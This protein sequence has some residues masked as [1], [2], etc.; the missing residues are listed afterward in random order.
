MRRIMGDRVQESEDDNSTFQLRIGSTALR[1]NPRNND[2]CDDHDGGTSAE[3]RQFAAGC[4][5]KDFWSN[6]RAVYDAFRYS[7]IYPWPDKRGPRDQDP[8]PPPAHGE[9]QDQL[10]STAFY[11]DRKKL[12]GQSFRLRK[13][14]N[15]KMDWR[16][17]THP[18][19]GSL[20]F[21]HKSDINAMGPGATASIEDLEK[22]V[23]S[24][25]PDIP[26]PDG[27]TVGL[28]Y[29]EDMKAFEDHASPI[30]LGHFGPN[31][32]MTVPWTKKLWLLNNELFKMRK[33]GIILAISKGSSSSG[34][35]AGAA[36]GE[37]AGTAAGA[38]E[39]NK[40][41]LGG[42]HGVTSGRV[43]MLP[44]L[45]R[46][47]ASNMPEN[48]VFGFSA[49]LVQQPEFWSRLKRLFH[50]DEWPAKTQAQAKSEKQNWR[51]FT[52]KDNQGMDHEFFLKEAQIQAQVRA[53]EGAADVRTNKKGRFE[54]EYDHKQHA[55]EEQA[56]DHREM[57][58]MFA[59]IEEEEEQM[60]GRRPFK[61]P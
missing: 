29:F 48:S 40:E 16:F 30:L 60:A 14:R 13:N 12:A 41:A 44:E 10:Y 18:A 9:Q 51:R 55:D 59:K 53:E 24:R 32:K 47:K 34:H 27:E 37:H 33:D 31:E 61:F 54:H 57:D 2:N 20:H 19:D 35:G 15:N 5:I 36:A 45:L 49:M 38:Q 43:T 42:E 3:D 26:E 17:Q 7:G 6:G 39:C 50:S 22:V 52:D 8:T 58:Q 4:P 11:F 56:R 1:R 46:Q 28:R 25:R 21:V 23:E